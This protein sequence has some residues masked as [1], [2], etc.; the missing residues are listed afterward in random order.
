[1]ANLTEAFEREELLARARWQLRLRWVATGLVLLALVAA[2]LLLPG[3]LPVGR[4]LAILAALA[5]ANL[6]IMLLFIPR[7]ERSG[8]RLAPELVIKG[9]IGLDL[10]VYTIFLHWSGGAENPAAIYYILQVIIAAVLLMGNWAYFSAAASSLLYAMVLILEYAGALPHQ[11]LTGIVDPGVYRQPVLLLALWGTLASALFLA[12]YLATSI[13]Q[14]LRQREQQLFQSN[15]ACEVRSGELAAANQ[16]LNEMA[17]A[18]ATFLLYVTHDLRAPIA[19]IQ[20]YLRLLR[21]GYI[22]EERVFE[23]VARAERRAEEVL[24]LIGD[25]LDLRQV[26]QTQAQDSREHLKPR[27]TLLKALD[28]L[29]PSAIEKRITI[30]LDLDADVPVVFAD[31]RHLSL[32][33]NNLLSNAIK[34]TPEDGRVQVA[35][36][37]DGSYLCVDVADTGIGIAPQDHEKI[38][39][40]FYRGENAR[41]FAPRGTGI[42]LAIVQRVISMYSGSIS[43]ESE[44]GKGST[45][46]VR[47]PLASMRAGTPQPSSGALIA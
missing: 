29:R 8:G 17:A 20:S 4:L 39:Q 22:E 9:Q 19:A 35:M 23:I 12:A 30:D 18:R 41:S 38:F 43:L 42:G 33:W 26:E 13:V 2:S 7:L 40:E 21:E 44:L 27:E 46:H 3:V 24:E 11:H 16:R 31:P 37:C 28:M 47:L 32:L 14:K 36:H 34:Y 15:L 45:F 5:V 25:L 1:M 10:L 6:A